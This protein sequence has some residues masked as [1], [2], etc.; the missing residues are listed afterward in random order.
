MIHMIN[1]LSIWFEIQRGAIATLA[2][3]VTEETVS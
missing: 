1:N 3:T 2:E